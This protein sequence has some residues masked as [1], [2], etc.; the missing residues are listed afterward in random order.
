MAIERALAG[1]FDLV[2]G[3][4]D[5]ANLM[6]ALAC[7]VP[8]IATFHGRLD[9]PAI[10]VAMRSSP[11]HLLAISAHQASTRPEAN[12]AAVIHNGLTLDH[13]PF[14]RRRD[15]ALVFAGRVTP[16][17]GVIDAIDVAKQSGRLL[18]IKSA[19]AAHRLRG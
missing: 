7:P 2:H 15:D 16:E 14:E 4:L 5:L 18:R 12:W 13:V 9:H 10:G 1:E 17:K 11:G 3:H 8:V 19:L 6:I